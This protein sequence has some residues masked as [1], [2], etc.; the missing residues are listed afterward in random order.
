MQSLLSENKEGKR[1]H[2]WIIMKV[3]NEIC[4]SRAEIAF[5]CLFH[6]LISQGAKKKKYGGYIDVNTT[7]Q[8]YDFSLAEEGK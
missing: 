4:Q 6:W 2:L 3:Q 8:P 7:R 5:F 1:S